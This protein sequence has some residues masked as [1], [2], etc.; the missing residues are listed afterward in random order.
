MALVTQAGSR[1]CTLGR[2]RWG[3]RCRI[4]AP[5]RTTATPTGEWRW[6][7]LVTVPWWSGFFVG[8]HLSA[9]LLPHTCAALHLLKAVA[10]AVPCIMHVQ[11]TVVIIIEASVEIAG[12]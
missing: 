12:A 8:P 5:A 11:L 1:Q 9:L 4:W 2:W 10:I 6:Q 7:P 3:S